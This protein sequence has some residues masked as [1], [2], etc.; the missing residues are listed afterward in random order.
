MLGTLH[1][2]VSTGSAP[3]YGHFFPKTDTHD[4]ETPFLRE[5]TVLNSPDT[6]CPD[7]TYSLFEI[8]VH[9]AMLV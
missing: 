8:S 9:F 5:V 1:L 4:C 6:S 7:Y 2:G 3:I